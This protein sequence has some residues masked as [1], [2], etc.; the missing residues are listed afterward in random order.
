MVSVLLGQLSLPES[1]N[2]QQEKEL[3]LFANSNRGLDIT[4]QSIG[5]LALDHRIYQYLNEQ[6]SQL[7]IAFAL[8]RHDSQTL[9][10]NGLITGKKDLEKKLKRII[11]LILTA[12]Q[13]NSS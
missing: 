13:A 7:L 2:A 1:I 4:E 11:G 9:A 3:H 5:S 10:Q 8:Q 12:E 6:E